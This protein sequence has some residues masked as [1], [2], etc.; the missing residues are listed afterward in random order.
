MSYSITKIVQNK[1]LLQKFVICKE[2][3]LKTLQIR[4]NFVMKWVLISSH[5]KLK[6]SFV[7]KFVMN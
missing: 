6:F 2:I 4:K 1:F 7:M 3:A 5:Y